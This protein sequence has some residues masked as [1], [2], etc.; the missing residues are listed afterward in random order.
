[1][2]ENDGGAKADRMAELEAQVTEI[3]HRYVH[4][5]GNDRF[6]DRVLEAGRVLANFN[7]E[8]QKWQAVAI[9]ALTRAGGA[10][11]H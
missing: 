7:A 3:F 4:A 2:A 9:E 1:M 10:T 8:F 11:T 6:A 5:E